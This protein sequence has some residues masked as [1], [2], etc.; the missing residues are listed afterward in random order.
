[1][2]LYGVL[3]EYVCVAGARDVV[4]EKISKTAAFV[5]YN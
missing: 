2:G 1:M 3:P 5:I 4:G